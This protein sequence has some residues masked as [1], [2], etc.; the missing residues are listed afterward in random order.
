MNATIN[1]TS[2][3]GPITVA[4]AAELPTPYNAIAVA[5]AIS[6]WELDP[7]MVEVTDCS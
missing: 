7:I 4:K 6:K 5:I 3:N 2:H 1:G